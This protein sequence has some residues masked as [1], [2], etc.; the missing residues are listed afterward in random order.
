MSRVVVIGAGYVGLPSAIWLTDLGHEVTVIDCAPERVALLRRLQPPFSCPEL[1]LRLQAAGST[2]RLTFELS[3]EDY[4]P[5]VDVGM[6]MLA[7]PADTRPDGS[8]DLSIVATVIKTLVAW[9]PA[10]NALVCVRS[11]LSIGDS[12]RI[13]A[14]VEDSDLPNRYVYW[15]AF[16]GQHRA[17][18]DLA[19]P[20]RIVLG[21]RR[22]QIA[23]SFVDRILPTDLH[24]RVLTMSFEEAE[25]TKQMSNSVLA[26]NQVLTAELASICEK[27]AIK[28]EVV[29][30]GIAGDYRIGQE[31]LEHRPGLGDLCLRKDLSAMCKIAGDNGVLLQSAARRSDELRRLAV[32]NLIGHVC[33]IGPQPNVAMVGLGYASGV[34]DTRGALSHQLLAALQGRAK[35]RVWDGYADV[36]SVIAAMPGIEAFPSLEVC[37]RGADVAVLLV[38]HPE[39]RQVD[40]QTQGE[41]MREVHSIFDFAHALPASQRGASECPRA[42]YTA[43]SCPLCSRSADVV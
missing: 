22:A 21:S 18:V 14:A 37:L 4:Q 13:L 28:S 29:I 25:A 11:T 32:G 34:G 27:Y 1:S 40:W 3:F 19:Q 23:K 17:F 36:S 2:E 24:N 26:V 20:D 39:L 35:V 6:V 42:W 41:S 5:N 12:V 43:G 9:Q 31:L 8:V 30:R 10:R 15:P 16:L 7:V 33:R 38:D